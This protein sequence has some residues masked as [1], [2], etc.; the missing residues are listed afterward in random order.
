MESREELYRLARDWVSDNRQRAILRQLKASEEIYAALPQLKALEAQA[1]S[2]GTQ[3][4][5]AGLEGDKEKRAAALGQVAQVNAQHKALLTQAGYPENALDTP[6]ACPICKDT[7]F[8]Q[9]STCA[10]VHRRAR[11]LRRQEINRTSPLQLSDFSTFLLDKYPNAIDPHLGGNLR[12]YMAKL[13]TFAQSYADG[14]GAQSQNLLMMGTAGLGKTKL[15]LAIAD[16]VLNRGYDVIYTSAAD[17]M[18]QLGREHFQE[19]D[20]PW[21]E[22]VKEA[23]LLI[24][25][26]LGTE[27]LNAYT[28]SALYELVN[29]RLL[30]HRPTIYTTN[31]TDAAV[32]ESRYTEKIA[33]RIL[34]NCRILRFFGQDIRVQ[35]GA[36]RRKN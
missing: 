7:G 33:S 17:L 22:S 4:M 14:F 8:A 13:L 28:T 16:R 29:H 32:I 27:F 36:A 31:I 11:E 19:E 35:E 3:A 18:S 1:R 24:L 6:W 23:D 21:M 30:V 26:D 9:G 2:W 5:L 10:C 12:A 15:A 25:D 34:G 20:S